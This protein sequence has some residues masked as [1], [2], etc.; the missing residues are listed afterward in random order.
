MAE[1]RGLENK[2][3]FG[4]DLREEDEPYVWGE[5]CQTPTP[6]LFRNEN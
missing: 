1:S 5:G 2:E 4:E 6:E 3:G